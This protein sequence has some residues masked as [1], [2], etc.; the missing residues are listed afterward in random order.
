MTST[1]QNCFR[2][3]VAF[4][5]ANALLFIFIGL[6]YLAVITPLALN[7]PTLHNYFL[8]WLFLA[9]ASIGHFGLLALLC[10]LFLAPLFLFN[11][12]PTRLLITTCIII[13]SIVLLL[14][15]TDSLVFAQFRFHLNGVIGQMILSGEMQQIFNLSWLEWLIIALF[16][17]GIIVLESLFARYLWRLISTNAV[18]A[19]KINRAGKIAISMIAICYLISFDMFMLG[20]INTALSLTPQAR[21]LPLYNDVIALLLPIKKSQLTVETLGNANF[22]QPKQTNQTLQY[23][24]HALQCK[25]PV[26]PFNIV[27]IVID[28]WRFDMLNKEVM[29][30]L[31]QFSKISTRFNQHIS[32]GNATQSGI[33]SLFYGLPGSYWT[34][35][36]DQQKSPVLMQ[37]LL[38]QHYQIGIFASAELKKPA[39]NHTVFRD[40]PGL[41]DETPGENPFIRDESVTDKF[42]QFINHRNNQKPFFSFLFYDGAH[43]YCEP[44]NTFELFKPFINT[45]NHIAL[46]E[47][48]NPLP[49]SNRYK[50][51][52]YAVDQQV[53]KTIHTLEKSHL[54]Q[55]TVVIITSDHGQEFNDNHQGFWEHASNYTAYQVQVPLLIKW[56]GKVTGEHNT[57]TSHFDIAPTLLSEVLGCSNSAADYSIGQSLFSTNTRAF[58]LSSSYIDTGIIEPDRITTLFSTGNYQITDITAQPIPNAQLHTAIISLAF[59]EMTRFYEH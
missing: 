35:I 34:S 21:A 44:G 3:L 51:A 17:I 2:F 37:E 25:P 57:Q 43:S 58:L 29:P 53:A 4:T 39:F 9:L 13:Q 6:R 52:L 30:H 45:C 5:L 8:V 36:L 14:L 33:F 24:L 28:T 10:T 16:M 32:G 7:V 31:Y 22:I 42:T 19:L 48:S 59:K 46:N 49:Y 38:K 40:I 47:N 12:I 54:L 18:A 41:I 55:N 27:L 1:K 50:N 20:G 11:K 23:P 15:I 56:P 26:Q